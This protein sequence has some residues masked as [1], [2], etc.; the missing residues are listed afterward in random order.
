MVIAADVRFSQTDLMLSDFSGREI[1]LETF[2]TVF[3]PREFVRDLAQRVRRL[4]KAHNATTDCEGMGLVVPGMVDHRSGRI[5][6]APTL[7][8][9][10]VDLREALASATGLPVQ[11]ENAAKACVLSQMWLARDEL[12]SNQDFAFV[13]VSDG[14]GVGI[15]VNGELFRG[16]ENMAGEFGHI[17]LSMDGP[18]CLCGNL[19]CWEAYISNIATLSRYLG[20]DASKIHPRLV[21]ESDT[22][23]L[24]VTDLVARARQGDAK[25]LTSIQSTARYLGLG[26]ANVVNGLNPARVFLTG[27]ITAAW[28]L[29]EGTVREALKERSLTEALAAT[30]VHVASSVENPRLRGAAA[31]VA[32]PT[33][34]AIRVA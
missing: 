33:F 31:L 11:V 2:S 34:A 30:R 29:I 3:S 23:R 17:P 25:A 9:H 7:N 18:R 24:T 20:R 4:L 8:W 14:V 10:N 28:D 16:H 12:A 32:A 21:L 5:L 19:G 22:A 6:N 1:A 26:L 27:E 15:V 13:T